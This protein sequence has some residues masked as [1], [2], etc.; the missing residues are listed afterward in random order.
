MSN[1]RKQKNDNRASRRM[2]QSAMLHGKVRVVR[3]A[4]DA[5]ELSD[6]IVLYVERRFVCFS[7]SARSANG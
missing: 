2:Y 1:D 5:K 7:L 3:F 6:G 4:Y